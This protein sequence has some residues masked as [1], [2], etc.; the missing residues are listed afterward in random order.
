MKMIVWK[1]KTKNYSNF[2]E[3][4][5]GEMDSEEMDSEEMDSKDE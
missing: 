5:S 1:M 2:E 4:D 3:T